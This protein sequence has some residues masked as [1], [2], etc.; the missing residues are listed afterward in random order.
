MKYLIDT[1]WVIEYLKGRE[2]VTKVLSSLTTDGLAISLFTYGEVYEGICFGRNPKQ[3]ERALESQTSESINN[4]D[5]R[6]L[7]FYH[8]ARRQG[9]DSLGHVVAETHR[10]L[11]FYSVGNPLRRQEAVPAAQMAHPP[12]NRS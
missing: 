7:C 1:D 2:R 5:R 12:D 9:I 11:R 3:N 8:G 10:H 6:V 4:Y